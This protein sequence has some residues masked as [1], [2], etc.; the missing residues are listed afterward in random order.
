M[1]YA[2]PKAD[3]GDRHTTQ[4]FELV[5][6][7]ALY[8][9]GWIASTTPK[10]IPWETAG[11]APDPDSFNWE[12]YHV[13]DDFSQAKNLAKENPA[14]LKE[15]QA[16]WDQEAKKYN[17]FPLDASFADRVDVRL[18]PSLTRGRSSFTYYPGIIRIP[19]GS[20]PDIKNKSYSITADVE[21]PSGGAS[22]VLAT[23][24]GD[25]G[26][27]GLILQESKPLFVYALSNQPQHKFK[28]AS[29]QPLSPGK[30]T[31]RFDFKYDGGGIGK[32][33]MGTLF[34]D[35]TQV[36]QAPI[37]RTIGVRFSLDETF[38][39]GEDTGTAVIADYAPQ[40]PFKFTGNLKKVTITLGSV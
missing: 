13:A 37:K 24:G 33:G 3:I 22:G 8:H 16:L 21:I 4:Y 29:S 11:A 5:G 23:Q 12:L 27:W 17:V 20:A 36:A 35:G 14:K 30:H 40:M 6:N 38:D 7:R 25:F 19:E 34:V 1:A 18:R 26:G 15:L 9:D 39:V 31:L 32:G 28:V 10:R 2:F